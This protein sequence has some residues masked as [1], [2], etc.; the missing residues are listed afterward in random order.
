MLLLPD[1]ELNRDWRYR[2]SPRLSS[3]CQG[4]LVPEFLR[5]LKNVA[6][7]T[8]VRVDPT[9]IS[10]AALMLLM[11]KLLVESRLTMAL[12][13]LPLVGAT[14]QFR[15][16][17]PLAVTGEPVTVKSEEGALKPTLV[18][19]PTTTHCFADPY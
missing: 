1:Q 9:V 16:S 8:V 12:A 14:F 4:A 10:P 18:T 15:P 11:L 2:C 19:V 6:L 3:A 5:G 17:V 7:P 13:V